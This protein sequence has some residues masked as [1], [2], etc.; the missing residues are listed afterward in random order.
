MIIRPCGGIDGL[1]WKLLSEGMSRLGN[2]I[3]DPAVTDFVFDEPNKS[4]ALDSAGHE[5]LFCK[6]RIGCGE[7]LE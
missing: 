1:H 4:H 5:N 2:V 7:I 3:G 6:L